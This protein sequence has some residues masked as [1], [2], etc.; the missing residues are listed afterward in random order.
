MLRTRIEVKVYAGSQVRF[1]VRRV[2]DKDPEGRGTGRVFDL[3]MQSDQAVVELLLSPVALELLWDVV[4]VAR[5]E[6]D[7]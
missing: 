2:A 7:R 3:L 5:G 4:R 6:D 1:E